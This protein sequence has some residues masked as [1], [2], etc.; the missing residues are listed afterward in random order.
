MIL[1]LKKGAQ[2][3]PHRI[4]G[5]RSAALSSLFSC[6]REVVELLRLV[7]MGVQQFVCLAFQGCTE[8]FFVDA[9]NFRIFMR[10]SHGEILVDFIESLHALGAARVRR[11]E[12]LSSA[13]LA[14]AGAGHDFDEIVGTFAGLEFIHDVLGILERVCDGDAHLALAEVDG[15][16]LDAVHAAH[17]EKVDGGEHLARSLFVDCAQCGFHDAARRT[18]DRARARA[19]AERAVEVWQVRAS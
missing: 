1:F 14:A 16:F 2:A 19:C 5:R 4:L 3:P 18:E 10:F 8:E 15:R 6:A 13:A 12:R 7:K 9:H 17:G 11:I